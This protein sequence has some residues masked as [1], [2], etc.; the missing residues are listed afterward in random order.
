MS[1]LTVFE[2]R[3]ATWA[4]LEASMVAVRKTVTAVV[5]ISEAMTGN[6]NSETGLARMAIEQCD[7]SL[8]IQE[9]DD[10]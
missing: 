1:V 5:S 4:A 8:F 2:L 7:A 3:V 9:G 10:W 6:W